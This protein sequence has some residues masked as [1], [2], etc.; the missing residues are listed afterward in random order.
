MTVESMM[1]CA[2]FGVH[3]GE[4]LYSVKEVAEIVFD[5]K[6]ERFVRD[7]ISMGGLEAVNIAVDPNGRR[8]ILIRESAIDDFLAKRSVRAAD[9]VPVPAIK[10]SGSKRD[11]GRVEGFRAEI[12]AHLEQRKR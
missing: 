3:R 12:R 11:D 8:D 1:A 10:A 4:R 5:G 6:S 9:K 2:S 7:L